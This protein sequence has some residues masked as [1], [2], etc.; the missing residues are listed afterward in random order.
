MQVEGQRGG[1]LH[2]LP[3]TGARVSNAYRTCLILGN[4]L[5]KVRL[6]PG[7]PR[8]PHGLFG[9]VFLRYEMAVRPISLLAG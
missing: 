5:A 8:G 9:K 1:C 3:A 7:V 6:M 2:S 4:S